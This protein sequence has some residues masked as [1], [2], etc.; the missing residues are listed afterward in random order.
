LLFEA[1]LCFSAF[2]VWGIAM[3]ELD[4]RGARDSSKTILLLRAL[5]ICAAT[6]GIV[7][8]ALML[9]QALGLALGSW[10]S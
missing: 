5:R 4:E 9:L 3:R 6:V 10:I 2:G 8:G 7:A 1:A